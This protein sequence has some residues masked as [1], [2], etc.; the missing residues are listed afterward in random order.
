M[1]PSD[2]IELI[3]VSS[4]NLAVAKTDYFF[5]EITTMDK[6]MIFDGEIKISMIQKIKKRL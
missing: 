1:I 3:T 6:H 2:D 4:V 5:P